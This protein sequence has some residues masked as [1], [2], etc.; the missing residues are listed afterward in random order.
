ML[1]TSILKELNHLSL[2]NFVK[3]YLFNHQQ[4]D[5]FFKL[6]EFLQ[7]IKKIQP[8]VEIIYKTEPIEPSP[9][10]KV[11][12][13]SDEISIYYLAIPK[14]PEWPPFFQILQAISTNQ[15]FLSPRDKNKIKKVNKPVK[16]RVFIMPQCSFCPLV[17]TLATQ[18]AIAQPL[19]QTFIIDGSL[20]PEVAQQYKITSAPTV[21]INEDY[22]L[23]GQDGKEKL[24]DWIL[25]AGETT[26]DPEVLRSLLNQGKAER[27]VELCLKE[28]GYLMSLLTLLKHEK[29]FTRI[30]AMRVLEELFDKSPRLAEKIMPSLL[31]MLE[32]SEKRD[33]DDLLFLLGIIG[34]PEAI[35]KLHQIAQT[36]SSTIREAAVEAIEHIKERYGEFH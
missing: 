33:K 17:V 3:F 16:I 23:V 29:I 27:I 35:P 10:L 6:D 19:I 36:T 31:K 32:T 12:N 20:Y 1:G 25:K 4:P 18:L 34:T 9:M 21:V 24:I 13:I 26:Y 15:S 2:K 5:L 8:E 28:E 14:G 22:F 7:D 11:T 30:G